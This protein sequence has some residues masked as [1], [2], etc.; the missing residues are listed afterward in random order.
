MVLGLQLPFAMLGVT[1]GGISK[2]Q[3]AF[4]FEILAIWLV[5]AWSISLWIATFAKQTSEAAF[6]TSLAVVVVTWWSDIVVLVGSV[7]PTVAAKGL[8][9]PFTLPAQLACNLDFRARSQLI[10]G[11]QWWYLLLAIV[12]F[13]VAVVIFRMHILRATGEAAA[14]VRGGFRGKREVGASYGRVRPPAVAWKDFHYLLG[15]KAGLWVRWVTAA[16]LVGAGWVTHQIG[17][18]IAVCCLLVIDCVTATSRSFGDEAEEGSPD[19]LILLPHSGAFVVDQKLGVIHINISVPWSIALVFLLVNQLLPTM[20][21]AV[22]TMVAVI[23]M[24]VV[25]LAL[26]GVVCDVG[27]ACL[28]NPRLGLVLGLIRAVLIL[29]SLAMGSMPCLMLS[30]LIYTAGVILYH[31]TSRKRLNL[32]FEKVAGGRLA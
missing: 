18:G 20:G 14:L 25:F 11:A 12:F 3:V 26:T 27:A 5:L 24:M 22:A 1:L 15:G 30:P 32:E 8:S 4:A 23:G 16:A 13:A 29:G 21:W 31:G 2:A 9:G 19:L 10:P 17:W 7:I 6:V 28:K